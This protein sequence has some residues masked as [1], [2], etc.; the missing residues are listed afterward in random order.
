MKKI[1]VLGTGCMKCNKLYEM[2]NRAVTELG[3]AAEVTKVEDIQEI[4]AKGV[5][6]TP[7]LVVDGEVKSTGKVPTMEQLKAMLG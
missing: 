3:L 4:V 6:M 7:G 5:M 2:T 1:E